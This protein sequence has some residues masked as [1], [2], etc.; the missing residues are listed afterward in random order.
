[1]I[2]ETWQCKEDTAW[3]QEYHTHET[4]TLVAQKIYFTHFLL[5]LLICTNQVTQFYLTAG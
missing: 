2:S 3:P 1:M 5:I 4:W